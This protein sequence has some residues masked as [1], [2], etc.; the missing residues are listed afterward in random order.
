MP[1]TLYQ[2]N[3]PEIGTTWRC[4]FV[5]ITK[6]TGTNTLSHQL[7]GNNVVT[8]QEVT[9]VGSGSKKKKWVDLN[10]LLFHIILLSAY[11]NV[12]MLI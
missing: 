6:T 12:M 9:F 5:N 2:D 7:Q 1:N 4:P 8:K 10:N 3:T 11:H